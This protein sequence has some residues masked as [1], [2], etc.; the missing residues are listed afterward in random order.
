[1]S[2]SHAIFEIFGNTGDWAQ[3]D[4]IEL[5]QVQVEF[6]TA[7][8]PFE[9]RNAAHELLMCQRYYE[10]SWADSSLAGLQSYQAIAFTQPFSNNDLMLNVPYKVVKRE[11]P[12]VNIYSSA[13]QASGNVY[14][15]TDGGNVSVASVQTTKHG[16]SYL[17]LGSTVAAGKVM[18]FHFDASSEV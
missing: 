16:I 1:M 17:N 9:Y 6:G 18:R 12:L 5:A 13:N 14:N 4:W 7:A 11:L 15:A 3:N 10:N 2:Y 8:T